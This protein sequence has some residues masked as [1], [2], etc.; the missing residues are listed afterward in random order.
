MALQYDFLIVGAG[1]FG[2]V[3][4][5]Q[6]TDAGFK[7]LVID[8][9]DHF[10][11]NCYTE[12]KEGIE[13]H[14][15]GPHIFHTSNET[16]W[17]YV[18][19][20]ASFNSFINSPKAMQN[21]RL[22]S[23]PFSMN[24]FYELW[25]VVSPD[26][27]K[28][29]IEKQR[30]KGKINNLEEQ[31]LAFVGEDIYRLLIKDYTEKQW[32]R[33]AT[34]LPSFIIKRL[35]LRFTFDSNY[36]KDKYQGIPKYGYSQM[37]AKMLDGIPLKL[38]VDFCQDKKYWQQQAANIVFTGKIDEYFNYQ[39]GRLEYRTLDF[40]HSVLNTD[41]FQGNAV[42]NFPSHSVP[43]TRR[44]EHRHFA[45]CNSE[46]TIVTEE[47]PRECTETDI[48]YYPINTNYNSRLYQQYKELAQQEQ[49]VIFGGRLAEYK[50]MDMHVVIESALNRWRS[51]YMNHGLRLLT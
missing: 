42:I 46:V 49:G 11:G 33:K 20:F 50:Y 34:E 29:I 26:Q 27:A 38:S 44:I 12:Q 7:C 35:P 31:A 51:W 8:R 48:P 16:V 15:Y 4:A 43:F 14:T 18:N 23:L 28:R 40:S 1:L 36:F 30:W 9:R 37:M 3:F 22:Y 19:R 6:A 2:S 24:T 32:G 21:G 13:V 5:R 45:E 25:G 39:H 17:Q 47:T 10:G 41:N